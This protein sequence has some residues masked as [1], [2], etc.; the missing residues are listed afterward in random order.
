MTTPWTTSVADSISRRSSSA[1]TAGKVERILV[2]RFHSLGDV[3]L[4]TGIVTRLAAEGARVEVATAEA[5]RPVFEGM[6]VADIWNPGDLARAGS[7][8]RV[9]DL[10]SNATSRR[11]L[12]SCGPVVRARGRSLARRWTVFWGRR[13]PTFPVPHCVQR[14]GETA[15]WDG[16]D[17]RSLR[18][19]MVSTPRDQEEGRALGLAWTSTESPCVG[20]APGASRAMKR[21]PEE[22]FDALSRVL[23]ARGLRTLRF[24]EPG[25]VA[26]EGEGFVRATIRPL[27]AILERCRALVTNDSGMMHLGVA[28]GVPVVAIFGSTVLEFGFGPLGDRDTVLEHDLA[29][30]PCAPHGARYCWQ[31]HAGCLRGVAVADVLAAVLE[32]ADKVG[33]S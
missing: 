23:E 11:L 18:P 33:V 25:R 1:T 2:C 16:M 8:D 5:L 13:A 30:R 21:W 12:A 22:R 20:I 9:L 10:Q 32:R 19:R 31:G 15:G 27:K 14:Y 6:P 28:L 29:C 4:S 17:A 7:F 3:V 26:E 24:E